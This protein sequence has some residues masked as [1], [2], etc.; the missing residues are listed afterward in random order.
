MI[1]KYD[2]EN[3]FN[4]SEVLALK[5]CQFELVCK[6]HYNFELQQCQNKRKFN[7]EKML[8]DEKTINK[9]IQYALSVIA[10]NVD[11]D[12]NLIVP[13]PTSTNEVT[14]LFTKMVGNPQKS[15]AD[16]AKSPNTAKAMNS[17]IIQGV[18]LFQKVQEQT[19]VEDM[20][21]AFVSEIKEFIAELDDDILCKPKNKTPKAEPEFSTYIIDQSCANQITMVMHDVIADRRG[22]DAILVIVCAMELGIITRLPYLA[23]KKEFPSVGGR[24]NYNKYLSD[25]FLDSEK[26][27]IKQLF[28]KRLP[29]LFS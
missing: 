26:E 12:G 3:N 9:N 2:F 20:P 17:L 22:K 28:K 5:F 18:Q 8:I 4:F 14:D 24:S 15:F 21:S 27:P 10:E 29:Q 1:L 6:I 23:A 7:M 11:K 13:E 16:M 25:G 19:K